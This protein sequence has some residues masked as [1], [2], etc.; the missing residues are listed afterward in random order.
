[1]IFTALTLGV[2]F[3]DGRIVPSFTVGAAFGCVVGPLFGLPVELATVCGM[4]GVFCGVTNCPIISLLIAFELFGFE[5]MAYYLPTVAVSYMLSS[6][7][8][9]YHMQKIMYSKTEA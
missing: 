6:Y 5:G 1:M 7:Y 2:G 4:L 8:G 9:L 3:K